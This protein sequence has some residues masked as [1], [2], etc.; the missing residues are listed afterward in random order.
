[1]KKPFLLLGLICICLFLFGLRLHRL[2]MKFS[3]PESV[4]LIG[5]DSEDTNKYMLA[6]IQTDQES[7][8]ILMLNPPKL[9]ARNLSKGISPAKATQRLGVLVNRVE[10]FNQSLTDNKLALGFLMLSDSLA[11]LKSG[12]QNFGQSWAILKL[13]AEGK[14]IKTLDLTNDELVSAM[15]KLQKEYQPLATLGQSCPITVS[16]ATGRS[17]LAGDVGNLLSNQGGL[18][19]RTINYPESL[20]D[21]QVLVDVSATDCFAVAEIIAASLT[22]AATVSKQPDLYS[23]SRAMIEVILGENYSNSTSS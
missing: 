17:G 19:V 16:N 12:N 13:L 11:K 15:L 21:T 9:V 5:T 2:Q 14:D 8:Q 4:L 23:N 18:V 6:S 7:S 3:A 1:M 22:E 10:F 20:K